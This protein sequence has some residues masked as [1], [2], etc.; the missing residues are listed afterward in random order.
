MI[1]KDYPVS[2][3]ISGK[4][5]MFTRPDSGSSPVSYPVP[6]KS[7]LKSMTESIAFSNKAYFKPEKVEICKPIKFLSFMT[8]YRGPLKKTGTSNF[9]Y[10]AV[11][12][13]DVCYK[14]YG[15]MVGL[16]DPTHKE[17]PAH[18]L[19]EVFL[20]RLRNGQFY[21][22]PF[23]GWKEF[24]PDYFGPLRE[25][26]E[27]DRQVSVYI[28]ALLNSMYSRPVNGK[29]EPSYQFN[30]LIQEGIMNYD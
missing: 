7:A 21:S 2:F 16:V 30:V 5:A 29:V 6:T 18:Q 3:E 9:Q 13:E 12:L 26:T 27:P 25:E 28:P 11:I 20:R 19:Q 24:V 1:T 15:K 8:N 17:N 23:L 22:T 14:V 4:Y 10:P